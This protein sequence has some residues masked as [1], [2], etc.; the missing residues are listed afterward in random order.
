LDTVAAA[1]NDLRVGPAFCTPDTVIT[2]PSTLL[3][4][5]TEKASTGQYIWDFMS[6]AGGLTPYGFPEVDTRPGEPSPYSITPQGVPAPAG[7]LWGVPCFVSTHCP[8]GTLVARSV[9]DVGVLVFQRMG[10]LVEY[11]MWAEN[12]W[13]TNSA[14]WRC[15][16]RIAFAVPR[17]SA[18]NIL[19]NLPF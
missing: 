15:E 18:V 4:L 8:D 13:Q 5:R 11:N 12:L 6:G 14:Q 9:K 17:P 10:M 3:G 1:F 2:H 19:T 16:E 7:H